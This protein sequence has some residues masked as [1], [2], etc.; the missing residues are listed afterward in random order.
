M[1]V[2]DLDIN[3]EKNQHIMALVNFMQ[4]PYSNPEKPEY[5]REAKFNNHRPFQMLI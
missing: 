5:V 1:L 4:K 2:K 3:Y